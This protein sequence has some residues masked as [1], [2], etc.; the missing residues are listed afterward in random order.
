ME[1]AK[2]EKAAQMVRYV[3]PQQLTEDAHQMIVN[4]QLKQE[5][6]LHS[7]IEAQVIVGAECVIKVP[8]QIMFPITTRPF[9]LN[10]VR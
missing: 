8:L 7:L 6:P 9:T 5:V 3:E 1:D 2:T 10:M 4:F